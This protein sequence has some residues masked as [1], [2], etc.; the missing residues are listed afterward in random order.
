MIETKNTVWEYSQT[1]F[2]VVTTD[3]AFFGLTLQKALRVRKRAE[4]RKSNRE[5]FA[6]LRS[7][8]KIKKQAYRNLKRKVAKI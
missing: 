7:C 8:G 3:L 2:F 6:R 1:V 4:N 5:E